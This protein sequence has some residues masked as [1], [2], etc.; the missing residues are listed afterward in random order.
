MDQEVFWETLNK[1]LA[2]FMFYSFKKLLIQVAQ[3]QTYKSQ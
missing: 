2:W 1:W 3:S